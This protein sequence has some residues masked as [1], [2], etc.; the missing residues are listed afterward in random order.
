MLIAMETYRDA[1]AAA[2][3][4]CKKTEFP[5][6]QQCAVS[7]QRRIKPPISIRANSIC[8]SPHKLAI[9][10]ATN[11]SDKPQN[12]LPDQCKSTRT[13]R[14]A[15]RPSFLTHLRWPIRKTHQ[16]VA[17]ES[18]SCPLCTPRAR[19]NGGMPLDSLIMA[20]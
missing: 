7:I 5:E 9:C 15:V 18:L 4:R 11:R 1:I 13:F 6:P 14:L 12:L 17:K 8:S 16:I 10:L 2:V 3:C 19:R 20:G